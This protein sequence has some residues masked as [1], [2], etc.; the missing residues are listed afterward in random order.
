MVH[1]DPGNIVAVGNEFARLLPDD[2]RI[3]AVNSHSGIVV[4][5]Q[6]A[7]IRRLHNQQSQAI[8]PKI[9]PAASPSAIIVIRQE[10]VAV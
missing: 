5:Q 2:R 3:A 10:R 9:A 4:Q 1:P 7:H 6:A 8:L